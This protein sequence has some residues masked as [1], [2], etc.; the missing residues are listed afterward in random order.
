MKGTRTTTKAVPFVC[1]PGRNSQGPFPCSICNRECTS[2]SDYQN[3]LQ[4]K[5]HI[6]KATHLEL[7]GGVAGT[8]ICRPTTT[9][10]ETVDQVDQ[11]VIALLTRLNE[12]QH[13]SMVRHKDEKVSSA[14]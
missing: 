6:R 4:G 10:V 13:A 2:L 5:E 12:L 9:V 1:F 14:Y 8:K 7:G 3:H 11:L